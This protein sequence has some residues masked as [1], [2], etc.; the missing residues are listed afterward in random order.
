MQGC[1]AFCSRVLDYAFP[2]QWTG[3][4]DSTWW[5]TFFFSFFF[6]FFFFFLLLTKRL[7]SRTECG[8]EGSAIDRY[9]TKGSSSETSHKVGNTFK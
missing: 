5:G 9:A 8:N 1:G 3:S 6:F 4:D 2:A 7:V